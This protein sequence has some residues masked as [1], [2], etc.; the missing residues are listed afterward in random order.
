MCTCFI[1]NYGSKW[2]IH[3]KKKKKN[4]EMFSSLVQ[5]KLFKLLWS[6]SE[7][8]VDSCVVNVREKVWKIALE[9]HVYFGTNYISR[10]SLKAI[11]NNHPMINC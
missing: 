5:V 10:G 1:L 3:T 6:F 9:G 11:L 7:N 4:Y 8:A 2:E